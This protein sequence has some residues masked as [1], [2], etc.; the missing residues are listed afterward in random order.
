[1]LLFFIIIY[2]GNV[3]LDLSLFL[4]YIDSAYIVAITSK[5]KKIVNPKSMVNVI[6]F[7]ILKIN[8]SK[9]GFKNLIKK[10]D[11]YIL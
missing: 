7:D 10:I 4:L 6:L 8:L 3:I 2:F 9:R 5:I 11:K 1:M